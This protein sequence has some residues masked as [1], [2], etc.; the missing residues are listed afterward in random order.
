MDYSNQIDE[1]NS[2]ELK[3]AV[4]DLEFCTTCGTILPL[5]SYDDHLMCSLC[6]KTIEINEWN[7][8]TLKNVYIVN[9]SVDDLKE[10]SSKEKI[11]LKKEDFIGTFV[12][13][14][15]SKCGHEGKLSFVDLV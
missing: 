12:D 14:K 13:R 15:C 10:G 9:E 6:K 8:K 4:N 3:F 5:P 11:G 1:A 7:G 2:N